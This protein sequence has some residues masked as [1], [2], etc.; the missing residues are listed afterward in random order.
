MQ[1]LVITV[2]VESDSSAL[3]DPKLKTNLGIIYPLPKLLDMLVVV[4]DLHCQ[5][6]VRYSSWTYLTGHR[7]L[8]KLRRLLECYETQG[9]RLVNMRTLLRELPP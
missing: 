2:D 3:A 8:D 5:D 4:L 1:Y 9:Y 7:F 6:F